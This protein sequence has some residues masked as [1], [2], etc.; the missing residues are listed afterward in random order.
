MNFEWKIL[1]VTVKDEVIVHARYKCKL[2]SEE[3]VIESEGNAH[4]ELSVG[5]PYKDITEQNIIDAVKKLYIQDDTNLIELNLKK[6]LENIKK[7]SVL[8]PWHIETFNLEL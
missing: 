2:T 4:G 8:P 7:S 6:Q 5:I 3:T 1:D